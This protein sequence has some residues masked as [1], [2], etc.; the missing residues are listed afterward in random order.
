LLYG[1]CEGLEPAFKIKIDSVL[2]YWKESSVYSFLLLLRN[3][4]YKVVFILTQL[5]DDKSLC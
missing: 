3:S 2:V 4:K 1:D 5:N